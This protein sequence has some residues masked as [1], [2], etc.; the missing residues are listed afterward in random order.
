[1]S[2]NTKS[3][4]AEKAVSIFLES[5]LSDYS[6]FEDWKIDSLDDYSEG[7]FIVHVLIEG[8]T[9]FEFKVDTSTVSIDDGGEDYSGDIEICMYE[10]V[11]EVTR[12]YDYTIKY[13]WMK[14]LK[15]D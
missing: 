2:K 11:Y 9:S 1:M 8:K 15:W 5:E 14:L 12:T 4:I 3:Y 6:H 13:F 7:V 10:D